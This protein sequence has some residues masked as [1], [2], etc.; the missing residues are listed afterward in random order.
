MC[1]ACNTPF[2]FKDADCLTKKNKFV[3]RISYIR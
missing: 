2:V 1:K 3:S